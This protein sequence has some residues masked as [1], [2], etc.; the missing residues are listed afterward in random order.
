[1]YY[2]NDTYGNIQPLSLFRSG[3]RNFAFTRSSFTSQPNRASWKRSCSCWVGFNTFNLPAWWNLSCF[4]FALIP[5]LIPL[6]A[7]SPQWME[8]TPTSGWRLRTN[9]PRSTLQPRPDTKTSA[10]CSHRWDY[11]ILHFSS[12]AEPKSL[13]GVFKGFYFQMLPI[14]FEINNELNMIT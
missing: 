8:S 11:L 5:S 13:F 6:S 7:L 4:L 12:R 9:A 2:V 3:P 10:T 1:M 14:E